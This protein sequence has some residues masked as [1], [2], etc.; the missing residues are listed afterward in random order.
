MQGSANDHPVSVA[1]ERESHCLVGLR[2]AAGRKAAEVGIPQ[3]GRPGLRLSEHSGGKLH[4]VEAGV[5]GNVAGHDVADEI[6]S[7]FVTGDRERRGWALLEA[8]PC[9]K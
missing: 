7:L 3:P 4:R 9:V 1:S 5:Q 8:E 2:G 6:G